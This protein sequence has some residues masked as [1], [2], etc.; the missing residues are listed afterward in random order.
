MKIELPT[1]SCLQLL[2][3]SLFGSAPTSWRPIRLKFAM[4]NVTVGI[5]ITPS[6]Y[7]VDDGVP[8]I[9]SLN[10]KDG[11]LT[12]DDL[13]FFSKED[14]QKLAKTAYTEMIS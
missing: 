14:N 7:Y 13:V 12:D 8:A 5:V 9:R 4:P 1:Y 11:R 3:G 2:P 10:V 6:K